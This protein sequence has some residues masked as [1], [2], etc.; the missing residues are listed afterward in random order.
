MEWEMY[1][2]DE[3]MDASWLLISSCFG[4]AQNFIF[5]RYVSW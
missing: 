4:K 5:L 2:I 3:V 1:V